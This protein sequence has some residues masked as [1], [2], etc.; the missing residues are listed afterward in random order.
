MQ[1]EQDIRYGLAFDI[2]TTTIVGILVNLSDAAILK[3][4]SMKNPTSL[5]GLDVISRITFALKETGNLQKVTYKLIEGIN[6]LIEK[7]LPQNSAAFM[8]QVVMV[9]NTTMMHFVLG[10]DVTSLAGAPF[11]PGYRG[12][13]WKVAADFALN[14]PGKV[15]VYI[16][17]CI[18]AH[19]GSDA[20]AAII[21][22]D[23]AEKRG[24]EILIDIG[25]NGEII[26]K[27]ESGKL[28]A[29]S[30][31]AGPV[32]EGAGIT[33][34][35]QAKEGAIE[36]IEITMEGEVLLTCIEE[37]KTTEGQKK[38][39]AGICGSGI[40]SAI[41]EMLRWNILDKSGAFLDKETRK[42]SKLPYALQ[43][44]IVLGEEGEEFVLSMENPTLLGLAASDFNLYNVCKKDKTQHYISVTAKSI[45]KFQLAKG[46]IYAGIEML[47]QEM[48]KEKQEITACYLAGTFGNHID[49]SSGSICKIWP[50]EWQD[51]IIP[52]G[53]AA[54]TGAVRLLLSDACKL[55]SEKLAA[56]IKHVSLAERETFQKLYIDAMN[57]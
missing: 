1:E 44:R 34:G 37:E 4:E 31:A 23:F 33:Y 38:Y 46:A 26:G 6:L 15:K 47:L 5:Y 51:K 56:E 22:T 21:A 30:T 35:M 32:F 10:M 53:N 18:D 41:S 49:I 12:G 7:L 13:L 3:T 39:P 8:E 42:K 9:G 48:D 20:L 45:R 57:F 40:I 28:Y 50:E 52:V 19:V 54:G 17:S 14:L 2:G 27:D 16:P 25:T 29:C 24:T 36:Q 43:R 11:K 55:Y